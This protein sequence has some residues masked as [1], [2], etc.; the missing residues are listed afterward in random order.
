MILCKNH[1]A[2]CLTRRTESPAFAG[3]GNEHRVIAA[4]VLAAGQ[5]TA[6]LEYAAVKIPVEGAQDFIAENSVA[7]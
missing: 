2:L 4:L 6:V 5:G 1:P 7:F 3:E